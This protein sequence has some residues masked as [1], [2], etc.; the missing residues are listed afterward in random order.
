MHCTSA[1]ASS[2]LNTDNGSLNQHS[3]ISNN[4][5]I[6]AYSDKAAFILCKTSN[7][8]SKDLQEKQLSNGEV[9][10]E[11][12]A[13]LCNGWNSSR[14]E[15][16]LRKHLLSSPVLSSSFLFFLSFSLLFFPLYFFPLL[17][18][19]SS[20]FLSLL[21]FYFS[22][23]GQP[24]SASI[25]SSLYVESTHSSATGSLFT[26]AH[27]IATHQLTLLLCTATHVAAACVGLVAGATD[28]PA[29]GAV[30]AAAP[31]MWILC[32]GVGA[33]GGDAQVSSHSSSSLPLLFRPL[34]FWSIACEE[35]R[36]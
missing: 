4:Y 29:L 7:P 15:Q 5:I 13:K 18:F 32:P 34:T 8:S 26:T 2:D 14:T 11:S 3:N 23:L 36:N 28:I 17:F 35:E 31:H 10:Y 24:T 9:M 6:G 30:R 20:A 12:V 19:L 27:M 21:I 33:Q 25:G 16:Q 22:C 1:S